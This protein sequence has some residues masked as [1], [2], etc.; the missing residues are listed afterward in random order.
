MWCYRS[1]AVVSRAKSLLHSTTSTQSALSR[2]QPFSCKDV[3]DAAAN[4][5][6]VATQVVDEA[7]QALGIACINICRF[8]DPAEARPGDLMVFHRGAQGSWMGHV[9]MV[10]ASYPAAVMGP[11]VHTVEGNSGPKVARRI[12]LVAGADRFAF[13]ASLRRG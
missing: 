11:V 7:T 3:F 1:C 12:R 5:D 9:A 4:H 8:V 13:F 10:E 2:V 6:A